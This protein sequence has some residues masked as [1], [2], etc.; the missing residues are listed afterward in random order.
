MILAEGM[1]IKNKYDNEIYQ[2]VQV[3]DFSVLVE[4]DKN[5]IEMAK[6][7]LRRVDE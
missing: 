1:K 5:I 3:L 4:K 6:S 7:D 2:I